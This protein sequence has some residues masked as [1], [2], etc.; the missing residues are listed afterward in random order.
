M[1]VDR[2]LVGVGAGL[3]L[4]VGPIFLAE[5]APTKIQ[6][7]VGGDLSQIDLQ[8]ARLNLLLGVL[9]QFA[10]VIGIMV[11][12]AMGLQLA[13]PHRW[14]LVLLFSAALSAAQ[15]FISPTMVESPTWLHRHGL[16]QDKAAAAR[17][18]WDIGSAQ[19]FDHCQF[20]TGCGLVW[21]LT[22]CSAV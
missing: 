13:T 14:R 21:L 17:K 12:Q 11:T 10:I 9:T 3:G 20:Y 6:G 7:A 8:H 5:I 16:L 4:C 15:W 19:S 22:S 2:T 18:L 1:T